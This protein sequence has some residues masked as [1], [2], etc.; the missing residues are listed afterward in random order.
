MKTQR[1]IARRREPW[2]LRTRLA[3]ARVGRRV[4]SLTG[5]RH[6]VRPVPLGPL[7]APLQPWQRSRRQE[8]HTPRWRS[9]CYHRSSCGYGSNAAPAVA[10]GAQG[11]G[12][13]VGRASAR[14]SSAASVQRIS[15]GRSI[16]R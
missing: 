2:R 3:R 4:H 10:V 13:A 16:A 14:P 5:W 6:R 9:G 8:R 12:A 1:H 15:A 11:S 7:A